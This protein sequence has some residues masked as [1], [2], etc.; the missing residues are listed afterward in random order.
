MAGLLSNAFL[1]LASIVFAAGLVLA[2]AAY[3]PRVGLNFPLQ[4]MGL[5]GEIA[6]SIVPSPAAPSAATTAGNVDG[7]DPEATVGLPSPFPTAT[8][9]LTATATPSRTSTETP[10]PSSTPTVTLTPSRTPVVSQTPTPSKTPFGTP[11]PTS[12]FIA[13]PLPTEAGFP[14]C[15]PSESSAFEDAL[16][17][18]INDERKAVGLPTYSQESQLQT[19]ARS[20]SADMACNGFFSHT[21]SDGSSVGGRVSAQGYEWTQVG[22]NIFATSDT[23]SE[24]PQLALEWWMAGPAHRAN[25]LSEDF[26]DIGIGYIHEPSSPFGGYFTAVFARP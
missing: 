18:L 21:G 10:I 3:G 7:S 23:S 14:D 24:A 17:G 11:A 12:T 1:G 22:E 15:S 5:L 8:A 9:S 4:K 19:A 26:S 2:A 16:L 25:I 6:A 13:S 20:H